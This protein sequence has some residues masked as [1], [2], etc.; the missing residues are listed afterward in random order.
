MLP[1]KFGVNWLLGLGQEAKNRFSRWPQFFH[2][3]FSPYYEEE[4]K[5]IFSVFT[6]GNMHSQIEWIISWFNN[7]V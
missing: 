6:L 2:F 7:T 5:G 4:T 3:V 1:T